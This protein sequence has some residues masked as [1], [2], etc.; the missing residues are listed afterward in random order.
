MELFDQLLVG[1]IRNLS[2]LTKK[3]TFIWWKKILGCEGKHPQKQLFAQKFL[4]ICYT[5]NGLI[6][7]GWVGSTNLV[8]FLSKTFSTRF[9]TK[10]TV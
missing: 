8:P 7:W 6:S 3:T 1:S 4:I 5:F 2:R 9:R 10:S